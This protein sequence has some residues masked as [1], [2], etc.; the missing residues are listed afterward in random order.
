MEGR[1]GRGAVSECR[2]TSTATVCALS[3]ATPLGSRGPVR[4]RSR[5]LVE[6]GG[7]AGGP[8]PATGS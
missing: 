2:V 7:P 5:G 6:Q 4:P 3:S 1:R 8:N